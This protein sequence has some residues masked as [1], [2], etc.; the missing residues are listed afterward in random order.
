MIELKP[1]TTVYQKFQRWI[2]GKNKRNSELLK[3]FI[4]KVEQGPGK[5]GPIVLASCNGAPPQW[6]TKNKYRHWQKDKPE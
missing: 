3:Y 1:N 2:D 5:T 4:L 6:Y